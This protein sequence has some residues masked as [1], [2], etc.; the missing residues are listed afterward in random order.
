MTALGA[1]KL[2]A[3]DRHAYGYEV[4]VPEHYNRVYQANV[5]K[6]GCLSAKEATQIVIF[7]QMVDSVR[8]DVTKGGVLFEGTNNPKA[9]GNAAELLEEAMELGRQLTK[10]K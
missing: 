1:E 6:L 4:A 3:L 2:Q 5:D 8:A 10:A 9:F 7:H